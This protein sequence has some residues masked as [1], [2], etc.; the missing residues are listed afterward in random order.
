MFWRNWRMPTFI[1]CAVGLALF[2][3]IALPFWARSVGNIGRVSSCQSNL[4]M[5]GLGIIQYAQDY[6]EKLPLVA[7][8]GSAYGW[9]DALQP[10]LKSTSIFLC[11]QDRHMVARKL[12]PSGGPDPRS[13]GYT[14]Y[15]FNKRMDGKSRV[16]LPSGQVISLDGSAQGDVTDARYAFRQIPTLWRQ[17][18][19]SPLHRHKGMANYLFIDG[20]VRQLVPSQVED[21]THPVF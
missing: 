10:Y 5:I 21:A 6:N 16:E 20:R 11:P 2:I 4:K 3:F 12:L 19:D 13:S 1:L 14:S 17:N 15:P 8:G 9:A 18:A 7:T